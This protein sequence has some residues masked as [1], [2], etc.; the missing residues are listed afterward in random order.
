MPA[1]PDP[2]AAVLAFDVGTRRIGVAVGNALSGSAR[3]L[4]TLTAGDWA[5]VDALL[6]EWQ[7][8]GLVVGLP[9]DLDGGEQPMSARARRFARQ[10]HERSRLPVALADERHTSQE[11]ARRFASQRARG[12]ARRQDAV[13][14]DALSAAVI[15]EAWLLDGG[16]AAEGSFS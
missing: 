6:R 16:Q 14:M 2:A 11:A 13:R 10:L 7:P 12:T 4:A 8:G 9:L 1:T 5:A 3:A 15:L